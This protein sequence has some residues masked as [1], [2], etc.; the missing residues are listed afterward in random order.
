MTSRYSQAIA[1]EFVKNN[2]A[3]LNSRYSTGFMIMDLV[4]VIPPTIIVNELKILT[5]RQQLKVFLVKKCMMMSKDSLLV[6]QLQ[7]QIEQ[8]SNHLKIF[9]KMKLG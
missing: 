5:L 6:I 8:F 1:W 3:F 2:W 7:V 4:K 9:L